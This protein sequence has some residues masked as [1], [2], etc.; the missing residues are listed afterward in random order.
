MDGMGNFGF[1]EPEIYAARSR[2]FSGRRWDLSAV[3]CGAGCFIVLVPAGGLSALRWRGA[4]FRRGRIVL[5][6]LLRRKP[7]PGILRCA[8]ISRSCWQTLLSAAVLLVFHP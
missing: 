3:E 1:G 6:G 8:A 7:R 2:G 4:S 5:R